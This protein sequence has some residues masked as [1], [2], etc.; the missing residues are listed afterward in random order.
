MIGHHLFIAGPFDGAKDPDR[1]TLKLSALSNVF[2]PFFEN[3]KLPKALTDATCEM[4]REV[5][6]TDR[7]DAPDGEGIV[8][9]GLVGSVNITFDKK[10]TQPVISHLAQSMLSKLGT[11]IKRDFR[12]VKLIRV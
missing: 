12:T 8:Q 4:A 6:V 7:T 9:V 2:G 11:L 5:L 1:K 10:D 3:D